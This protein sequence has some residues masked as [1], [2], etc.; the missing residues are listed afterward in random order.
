MSS[1]PTPPRR[2]A[3]RHST[4]IVTRWIENDTY[5][6]VNNVVYYACFDSAVNRH[7]SKA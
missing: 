1:H 2:D 3:F 4:D 6:H 5:R 7:S